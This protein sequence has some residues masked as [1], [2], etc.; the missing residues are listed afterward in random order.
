MCTPCNLKMTLVGWVI[1]YVHW[2]MP[3]HLVLSKFG[4]LEQVCWFSTTP[5]EEPLLPVTF[6]IHIVYPNEEIIINSFSVG[7]LRLL[8]PSM[9]F[10]FERI[11]DWSSE[12]FEA[13]PA[14]WIF[15]GGMVQISGLVPLSKRYVQMHTPHH[16]FT[17]N[18]I[19]DR[20]LLTKGKIISTSSILVSQSGDKINHDTSSLK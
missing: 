3:L 17:V 2:A 4:L 19:V 5:H 20:Q 8:K 7:Q 13:T 1:M 9:N 11:S 10:F 15:S 12:K 14:I 6:Q 18:L 16:I